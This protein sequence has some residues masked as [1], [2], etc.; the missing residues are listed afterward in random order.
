MVSVLPQRVTLFVRFV[1]Q[2]CLVTAPDYDSLQLV[3][4]ARRLFQSEDEVPLPPQKQDLN[5]RFA[6]SYKILAQVR[7]WLQVLRTSVVRP[8]EFLTNP[9]TFTDYAIG[10]C[11][12]IIPSTCG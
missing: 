5:R 11:Y 7:R 12:R 4:T 6:E 8:L 3:Y 9:G 1:L 10:S 2:G